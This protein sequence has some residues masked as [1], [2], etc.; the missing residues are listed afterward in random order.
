MKWNT[1]WKTLSRDQRQAWRDWARNNPVLLDQGVVRRVCPHK[2]F[3]IVL[4]NRA[5][6]GEAANPTVV[7]AAASWLTNVLSLD[8]AGPFTTGAG[9]MNFRAVADIGEAT[10]WFVWASAPTLDGE[11][12]PL[13]TLRFIK[14]LALTALATDDLTPNF[15]ADYRAVH[16]TFNGPGTNGA[17]PDDHFV[18]FRLHQYV[19][20][21]LGPARVLKGQIQVE[22]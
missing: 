12:A 9:S 15:A 1:Q 18:W 6:A 22:L 17:W 14:S 7:P 3:T 4:Q 20:G 21:Q 13:K 10:Q 19:S 5:L 2:A 16:G 11:T 8:N